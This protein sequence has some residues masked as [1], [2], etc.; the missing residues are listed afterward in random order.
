MSGT[1]ESGKCVTKEIKV[2][3]KEET[4]EDYKYE[5]IPKLEEV[6]PEVKQEIIQ[7][8]NLLEIVMLILN[9]PKNKNMKI[10]LE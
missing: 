10:N 9:F 5:E 6:K 8:I 2:E 3:V 1:W 7:E 4:I